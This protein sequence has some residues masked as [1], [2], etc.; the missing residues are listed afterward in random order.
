MPAPQYICKH[1]AVSTP[2]LQPT[3]QAETTHTWHLAAALVN[4]R[5]NRSYCCTT[6]HP[7]DP[8]GSPHTGCRSKCSSVLASAVQQMRQA[9]LAHAWSYTACGSVLMRAARVSEY[10]YRKWVWSRLADVTTL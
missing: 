7:R 6:Q 2:S 1:P 8:Q 3:Q 5:Q 10:W 9:L 4:R